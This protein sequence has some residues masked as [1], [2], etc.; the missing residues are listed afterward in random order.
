[1]IL[2]GIAV[3]IKIGKHIVFTRRKPEVECDFEIPIQNNSQIDAVL[4]V[5]V[6]GKILFWGRLF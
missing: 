3:G 6:K 5:T 1:M 2:F 4:H